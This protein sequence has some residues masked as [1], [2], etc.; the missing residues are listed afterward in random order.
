MQCHLCKHNGHPCEECLTCKPH[1]DLDLK[2]HIYI[3]NPDAIVQPDNTPSGQATALDEDEED[4]LRILT[5][6]I[7][8]LTPIELLYLQNEMLGRTL[9]EFGKTVE[10]FAKKNTKGCSTQRAFEIRKRMLL[11]YPV[12]DTVMLTNGRRK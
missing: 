9:T 8:Q 3:D 2:F 5:A 4:R 10:K 6:T 7:F 12:L 1:N 11:K